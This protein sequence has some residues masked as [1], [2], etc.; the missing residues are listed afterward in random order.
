VVELDGSAA[1]PEEDRERDHLRDNLL[2]SSGVVTLRF[3]WKSVASRLCD[4][5]AVVARTLQG[6]GWSGQPRACGPDCDIA[7]RG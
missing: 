4:V 2:A 1:H 7:Q 3:G 6:R 5:A